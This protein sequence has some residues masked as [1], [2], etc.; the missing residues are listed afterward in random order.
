MSWERQRER[1]TGFMLSL[2]VGIA[3]IFRRPV[4]RLILWPTVAYF[5][6][7]AGEQRRASRDYLRRVLGREPGW[8]D[9]WRHFHTFAICALDR[10]FL[11]AGID[12][13]L[14][15]DVRRT[16]S[17]FGYTRARRGCV[18][19]LAHVGSFETIRV[20]G[21]VEHRL[22][23]RVVMDKAHGRRFTS[24]LERLNPELAASILD[25]STRGPELVLKL[26]QAIEAG[27]LVCLMADRIRVGE[28][29]VDVPF[30]G[31]TA[32]FP[33]APWIIAAALQVPVVAGLA[34]YRGGGRYEACIEG[35]FHRVQ[36]DRRHRTDSARPYVAAYAA[37]L[38]TLLHD[39]PY[40]WANFYDFWSDARR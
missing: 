11:L 31:G 33:L 10:V 7:S 39:A 23:I 4:A 3:R 29:G 37:R 17:G 15:V 34:V 25:A 24:L 9:L 22:P 1:S 6:L 13:G 19:L 12:G 32:T 38:E 35:L 14:R 30:L 27:E 16:L 28:P 26:K 20:S 18:V 2:L 21:S 40:N 8:R 5:L 36:L